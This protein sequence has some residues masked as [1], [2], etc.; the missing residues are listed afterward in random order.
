[1][2]WRGNAVASAVECTGAEI[3][4]REEKKEQN[5]GSWLQWCGN[6]YGF[7]GAF[8]IGLLLPLAR[9]EAAEIAFKVFLAKS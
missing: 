2:I 7:F 1:M 9:P 5:A 8:E 6:N 3:I 4:N